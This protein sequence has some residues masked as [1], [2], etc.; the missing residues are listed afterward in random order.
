MTGWATLAYMIIDAFTIQ[1]FLYPCSDQRSDM[2]TARG[3]H[4]DMGGRLSSP[5]HMYV[6]YISDPRWV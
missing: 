3:E 6:S 4:G 5:L 2:E 1:V